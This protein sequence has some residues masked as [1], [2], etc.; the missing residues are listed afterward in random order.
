M[1]NNIEIAIKK[2]ILPEYPFIQN[3][4]VFVPDYQPYKFFIIIHIR[5]KMKSGYENLMTYRKEIFPKI[6]SV[7]KMFGLEEFTSQENESTIGDILYSQI[8][9]MLRKK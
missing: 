1:F 2:L 5:L 8:Q 3:I 6:C 7:L 9:A 4:S